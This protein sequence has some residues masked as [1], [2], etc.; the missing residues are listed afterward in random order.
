MPANKIDAVL[1]LV[2]AA[3]IGFIVGR[4]VLLS[5]PLPV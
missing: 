3:A 5:L 4:A 2:I 1:S